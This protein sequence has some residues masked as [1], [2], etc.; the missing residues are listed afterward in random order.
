MYVLFRE[1]NKEKS[2]YFDKLVKLK[3][4]SLETLAIDYTYWD[5]M[6]DFIHNND[7]AWAK[8]M[9]DENVLKTY[10]ANAI[11]IFRTDLSLIYSINNQDPD[12]I[13]EFP[14]PKEVLNNIFS[15]ERLCHF[16]VDSSAGLIEIRGATIHPTLDPQRLTPAQGYFLAARIWNKDYVNELANLAGG[17][18]KISTTKQAI[19]HFKDLLKNNAIMFSR[20]VA[21]WERKPLAYIYVTVQSKELESYKLFSR[22]AAIIFIGF[23]ISVMIFIAA[24]L[25]TSVSAPLV[26]ISQALKTEKLP[27][28]RALEKDA[29]EFGDILRL[30]SRFLEQKEKLVKEI[31]DRKNAEARFEQVAAAAE[32]WIWEVDKNGLYTYS[33]QVAEEIIGYK[34]GEIIAKKYFYDFFTPE[35]KEDLK[36]R[37]F[38]FFATKK[39]FRNFVNPNVHKNGSIVLL[40]TSGSPILDKEGNLL[41]YRGAD[42]DVTERRKAEDELQAAYTKLKETQDQLIQAEKLNAIGQLASGVAHEVRN[43]LGIILQGIDYLGNR[44]SDKEADISETLTMLKE[45]IKR[46]DAIINALLDF[47]RA[48]GLD[49]QPE[50][51]NSILENSLNLVK[52]R[53]KFENIEVT[54]ETKKDMPKVLAD[55]N[56]L[57][58]VF[59]NILLNA[60]QAMPEGGK[61]II[62]SYV[63]QLEETKNG[64]GNRK[65]DHFRIGEKSVIVEFEDAGVGIPAEQIGKIFDPFF[66]TK[67]PRAGAGLGLSV[68]RNIIHMHKGL[69]RAESQVGK[70]TKITIVLKIAGRA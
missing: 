18:I 5:E 64:I 68:S 43:P 4:A 66:T 8:K 49:L 12:G 20:E 22:N 13:K 51:L 53:F 1:G 38:E 24:F 54:L 30:I 23:I 58:Q 46:A 70:G 57:E 52:A 44:L 36:R 27:D 21:D 7:I 32:E 28:R 16:F 9:M 26:R 31:T 47:S 42:K 35:T 61:I 65:E 39:S 69:I 60:V 34:Q 48:A 3:G 56:K 50:D 29:S 37:A 17:E 2:I 6:V 62:R 33:S 40:E 41:G 19:P 55:K 10:Q 45:S 63:K 15:R 25:T 11:W 67:G 14:L 59:I